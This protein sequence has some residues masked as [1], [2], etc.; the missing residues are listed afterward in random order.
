[1]NIAVF[2]PHPHKGRL[3]QQY[4]RGYQCDILISADMLIQPELFSLAIIDLSYSTDEWQKIVSVMQSHH[5]PILFIASS[6]QTALLT[7]IYQIE[8][9]DYLLNPIQRLDLNTRV[10]VLL[11]IYIENYAAQRS[12]TLEH[13]LFDMQNHT[14][15][16][17]DNQV[18]LTQKEFAVAQLL[19]SHIGHPLSRVYI[20]DVVWGKD[21]AISGRTI[22]T[23]VS[24]IRNKLALLPEN[25][26]QLTS[27]YSFGYQLEKTDIK[28]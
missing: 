5:L 19:L 24:R 8:R 22:D 27:I 1:M 16:F 23:H 7:Q 20:Q 17:N 25:G 2:S 10:A 9:S 13:Y 3:I 14:V 21:S 26:Y 6:K 12:F 4:L 15:S 18:I 11:E 28:Q